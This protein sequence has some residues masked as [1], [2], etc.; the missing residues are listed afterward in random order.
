MVQPACAS[1]RP[2]CERRACIGGDWAGPEKS[3]PHGEKMEDCAGEHKHVPYD[4]VD[5]H[6]PA[7]STAHNTNHDAPTCYC[8]AWALPPPTSPPHHKSTSPISDAAWHR[9]RHRCMAAGHVPVLPLT[10]NQMPPVYASPPMRSSH[11][12][13]KP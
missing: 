12:C 4:V 5:G 8:H 13:D 2:E 7:N 1:G 6:C 3:A 9:V 11:S 10:K